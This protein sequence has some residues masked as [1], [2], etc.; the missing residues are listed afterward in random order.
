VNRTECWLLQQR[1][2]IHKGLKI[3]QNVDDTLNQEGK[4]RH[5]EASG[6]E[7]EVTTHQ[8]KKKR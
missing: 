1:K 2:S 4:R 6:K 8:S 3:N 5:N 7:Q